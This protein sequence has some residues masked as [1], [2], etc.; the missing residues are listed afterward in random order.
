M[1]F[2]VKIAEEK[3]MVI[4]ALEGRMDAISKDE[5]ELGF[6]EVKRRGK[7]KIIL[8][9]KALDHIDEQGKAAL[10]VF[11][12]WAEKTE[13]EVKL[14]EIQ[15]KV[16]E[17]LDLGDREGVHDSLLDAMNTF[18]RNEEPG[19]GEENNEA[20]GPRLASE[21]SR[22]PLFV[23]AGGLLVFFVLVMIYMTRDRSS[24]IEEL[25]KRVVLLEERMSQAGAQG[26]NLSLAQEKIEGLRDEFAEKSKQIESDLARLRQE[27]ES[28]S[29]R[30]PPA[31]ST[32]AVQSPR[33]LKRH[34]VLQGETLFGI[35]KKYGIPVDELRR[36][37]NL[38]PN[39]P[40]GVGQKLI[41]SSS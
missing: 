15:P 1:T 17:V 2:Q 11:M 20:L 13:S 35:S 12:K 31:T 32:P 28:A 36:L 38:K 27:M 30:T 23:I 9:F 33:G 18:R 25:Q 21:G 8:L 24:G 16:K 26:K 29:G 41:V 40:I 7:K 14:A 6:E 37:N 4:L 3:D 5:L 39:Q 10:S 19:M 34:T 22:T